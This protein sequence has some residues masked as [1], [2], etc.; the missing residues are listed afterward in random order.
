MQSPGFIPGQEGRSIGVVISVIA[1]T[2]DNNDTDE[3][4]HLN[5]VAPVKMLELLVMTGMNRQV[6]GA[7][8]GPKLKTW[9]Q[10]MGTHSR[11]LVKKIVKDLGN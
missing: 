6:M 8:P 9:A 1:F 2:A 5:Y 3:P 11:S 4:G 10:E 7:D